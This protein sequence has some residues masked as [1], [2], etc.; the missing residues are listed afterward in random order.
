MK[1]TLFGGLL[2]SGL[3]TGAE[4]ESSSLAEGKL[5]ALLVDTYLISTQAARLIVLTT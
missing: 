4:L 3:A 2:L 5:G 1:P